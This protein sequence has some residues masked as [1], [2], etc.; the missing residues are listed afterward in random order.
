MKPV[1]NPGRRRAGIG[2]ARGF[3]LIELMMAIAIIG[4]L[5]SIAVPAYDAYVARAKA[6]Q[7][8]QEVGEFRSRFASVAGQPAYIKNGVPM[9]PVVVLVKDLGLGSA[10]NPYVD[11]IFGEGSVGDGRHGMFV[12]IKGAANAP[13]GAQSVAVAREALHTLRNAGL[14]FGNPRVFDSLVLF[15]VRLTEARPC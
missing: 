10:K 12:M 2:A 5:A 6:S 1:F 15:N 13:A 8:V 4:I 3:T 14:V 11:Y 9:C 7:I